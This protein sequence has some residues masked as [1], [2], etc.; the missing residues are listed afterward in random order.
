MSSIAQK[1]H[2]VL[3]DTYALYLKTQ[4]YHWHVTGPY[5]K[6]LHELFE[7][8]YQELANAVDD[9][10]ERIRTLGER[11][12]ATFNQFN[13]LKTI[14]DGNSSVDAKVMVE[15][16]LKDN[17]TLAKELS[18]L[19]QEAASEADE[20]TVALLSERVAVHEKAAWMLQSS[21]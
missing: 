10:A 12:P 4:N 11:A 1:M 9:I 19:V 21:L 2:V 18:K 6:A 7:M 14:Q 8:Q 13:E 17:Q 3:A 15:E 5:F 16:L 20:G